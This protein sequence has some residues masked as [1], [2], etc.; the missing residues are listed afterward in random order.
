[1]WRAL[2]QVQIA[3]SDRVGKIARDFVRVRGNGTRFCPTLRHWLKTRPGRLLRGAEFSAA[4][5]D[6]DAWVTRS[7]RPS[8]LT[9]R[10]R[11]LWAAG[12]FFRGRDRRSAPRS[13]YLRMPAQC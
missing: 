12:A 11:A 5:S 3:T 1:M 4:R 2:A 13:A 8:C 6:E 9:G 10:L 7:I